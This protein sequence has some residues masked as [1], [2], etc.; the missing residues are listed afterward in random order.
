VPG[1]FGQCEDFA[2]PCIVRF[3]WA[4][5]SAHAQSRPFA[6]PYQQS[7]A[8]CDPALRD[9]KPP[10]E[11]EYAHSPNPSTNPPRVATPQMPIQGEKTRLFR[12]CRGVKGDQAARGRQ[13]PVES[14]ESWRLGQELIDVRSKS[15]IFRVVRV[16]FAIPV[17]S[18]PALLVDQVDARPVIVL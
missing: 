2:A 7:R 4:V 5:E 6:A 16:Q 12:A 3:A 13:G 1:I 10:C 15:P 14:S 18:H 17:V 11:C 8:P 9:R